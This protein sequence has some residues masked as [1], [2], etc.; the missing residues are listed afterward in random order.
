MKMKLPSA[1]GL[2]SVLV[3]FAVLCLT[4]FS[5]LSVSTVLSDGRLAEKSRQAVYDY[6]AADCCA[7]ELLSQLRSGNIP[8]GVTMENGVYRYRCALSDTQILTVEVAVTGTDYHILR[9]QAESTTHW[10]AD[11]K[12]HVFNPAE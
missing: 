5:L 9:W 11:E 2:S 7:E 6:Y 3:I 1:V 8:E 12:L 4:V 10:Q